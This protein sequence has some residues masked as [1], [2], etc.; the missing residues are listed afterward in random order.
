MPEGDRPA[1]DRDFTDAISW[2]IWHEGAIVWDGDNFASD[3]V[4]FDHVVGKQHGQM[5]QWMREAGQKQI[6]GGVP[7]AIHRCQQAHPLRQH[8]AWVCTNK[9]RK[10]GLNGSA[11]AG[12]IEGVRSVF[13]DAEKHDPDIK[14][15]TACYKGS[16]IIAMLKVDCGY[17]QWVPPPP[18]PSHYDRDPR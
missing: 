9:G 7:Y 3:A 13:H 11:K 1:A 15:I 14:N 12:N 6:A 2:S 17:D 16:E 10:D 5:Q 4:V 18:K 8:L